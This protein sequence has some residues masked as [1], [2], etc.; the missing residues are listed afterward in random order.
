MKFKII[1]Y[2]AF[3]NVQFQKISIPTA[4]KVIGNSKGVG[5]RSQKPKFLKE[6]M[7]LNWNF[8]GGGRVQT[9]KTFCGQGM[10]IFWNNTINPIIFLAW[11]HACAKGPQED[12]KKF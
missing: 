5:G 12:F 1:N 7:G 3:V 10:D 8:Q 4:W 6:S 11:W 9:K 2:S